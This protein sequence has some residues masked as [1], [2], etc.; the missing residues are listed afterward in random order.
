MLQSGSGPLGGGFK[1]RRAS[2]RSVHSGAA[3]GHSASPE[4][5]SLSP[6]VQSLPARPMSARPAPVSSPACYPTAAM[7]ANQLH[8]H[9]AVAA[10]HRQTME[11]CGSQETM[12]VAGAAPV[13][14][15]AASS[16]PIMVGQ[17]GLSSTAAD[18]VEPTL[19]YRADAFPVRGALTHQR[20]TSAVS[21]LAAEKSG[22]SV[23]AASAHAGTLHRSRPASP[24]GNSSRRRRAQSA[25]PASTND[26]P[27]IVALGK[28][29]VQDAGTV[30]VGAPH[31]L[32]FA[33]GKA[34][35]SPAAG[36]SAAQQ[37]SVDTCAL[38]ATAC[39][40]VSVA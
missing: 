21:Q 6:M 11:P 33:F 5:Q 37:P 29:E 20:P 9:K 19:C 24:A 39:R 35:H 2:A 32:A 40:S 28:D 8:G 13:D 4:S 16:M 31:A 15:A 34:V 10:L 12:H 1:Q 18:Y 7:G 22:V 3:S 26:Q 27:L 14:W 23:S 25:R 38:K 36:G 30:A 17:L